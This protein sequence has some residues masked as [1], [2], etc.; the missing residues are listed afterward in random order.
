MIRLLALL[1]G[2]FIYLVFLAVFLYLVGFIGNRY[3]FSTVDSGPRIPVAEAMRANLLLLSLFAVQHSLMARAW[4]K[5]FWT[6]IVPRSIERSTF[7]LS[8]CVVLV[9]L[10][11]FWEPMPDLVWHVVDPV[12]APAIHLLFAAGWITVLIASA[13]IGHADMTGLRH[14]WLY[15]RRV[16]YTPPEFRTPGLYKHLRHPMMLGLLAGFWATPAM[17]QGHLLFAACMTLYIGIALIW[18]ERD[19]VRRHGSDYTIYRS[20]VRALLP[21]FRQ[22]R[23]D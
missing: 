18:E 10:F 5:R 20:R 8:T 16:H 19:L 1:Y 12:A 3:S 4:F 23:S 9:A 7:V 11:R 15:F 6:R 17:S 22:S 2:L 14:V 21:R 13:Q